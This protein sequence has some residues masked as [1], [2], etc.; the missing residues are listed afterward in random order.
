M[1]LL[2]PKLLPIAVILFALSACTGNS[3]GVVI[4]ENN[5]DEEDALRVH[6]EE[7][8]KKYERYQKNGDEFIRLWVRQE[9]NSFGSGSKYGSGVNRNVGYIDPKGL[10]YVWYFETN[11]QNVISQSELFS[12]S[13]DQVKTWRGTVYSV[14]SHDSDNDGRLGRGDKVDLY[15]AND[16][17]FGLIYESVDYLEEVFAYVD[18]SLL[19]IR[20][21]EDLFAAN[22]DY[23]TT[24]IKPV[25]KIEA[26]K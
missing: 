8:Y 12:F 22:L 26:P 24:S 6:S 25:R 16:N 2:S 19:M 10:D 23:E 20:N 3:G 7:G 14:I 17:I 5:I 15:Y 1:K 11:K 4:G 9:S 21:G 13:E 18:N